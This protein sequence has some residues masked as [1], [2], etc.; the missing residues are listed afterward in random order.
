MGLILWM[1]MVCTWQ[2]VAEHQGRYTFG[3]DKDRP[4]IILKQRD[5]MSKTT[6]V[7]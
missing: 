2:E 1:N 4:Y 6:F 7:N 5:L 3:S